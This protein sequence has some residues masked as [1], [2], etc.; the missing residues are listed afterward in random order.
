MNRSSQSSNTQRS[1]WRSPW[2]IGWIALVAIVLGVNA[3]MVVLAV[4]TN[5]GLVRED[6]YERGR[7]VE[8][9]IVSRLESDAGWTMSI[10]TPADTRATEPTTIRFVVVDRAGQPVSPASVV[11]F[12][13]RPSD[14]GMDFSVPMVEE[15]PG[16][17]AARVAFPVG[18]VWDTL[19]QARDGGA[20][21]A[22]SQRVSIARAGPS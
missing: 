9:T 2:V 15:A 22:V 13:Y 17:F 12:A 14:A 7:D 20:A 8:R 4:A 1:A 6:Y 5:P 10:D 11:Y 18:G 3:T 19:V 16:R 21:Y